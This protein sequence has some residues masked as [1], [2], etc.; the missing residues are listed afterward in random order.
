MAQN[1]ASHSFWISVPILPYLQIFFVLTLYI[2]RICKNVMQTFPLLEKIRH[3]CYN[4]PEQSDFI[5]VHGIF[6]NPY[7]LNIFWKEPVLLKYS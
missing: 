1:A 5:N 2:L 6:L 7:F 4:Q 3:F